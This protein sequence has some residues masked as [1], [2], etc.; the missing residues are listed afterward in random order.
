MADDE[1][2]TQDGGPDADLARLP[3]P[4]QDRRPAVRPSDEVASIDPTGALVR[5]GS[6]VPLLAP[7]VTAAVLTAAA[8]AAVSGVAAAYRWMWPWLAGATPSAPPHPSSASWLGPGVHVSY[9]H[10]EMHWP[11]GR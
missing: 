5:A 3:I 6:D 10:I 1:R 7:V 8:A 2:V 9:T 4:L 11:L